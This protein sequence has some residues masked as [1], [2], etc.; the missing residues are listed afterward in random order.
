MLEADATWKLR[1]KCRGMDPDL[2]FP[3]SGANQDVA[4]AKATCAGCPV[5]QE[6]SD[7]ADNYG[8]KFGIWGGESSL[9][10]RN[11]RKTRKD[12]GPKPEVLNF[13]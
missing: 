12:P 9:D 4:L 11:R 13:L 3:E 6:C 1:A 10:R 7:Y 8:E 5:A 2:F